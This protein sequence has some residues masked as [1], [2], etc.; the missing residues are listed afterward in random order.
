MK[1]RY[2]DNLVVDNFILWRNS[3]WICCNYYR[4]NLN[5][6]DIIATCYLNMS[7]ISAP[8]K[9]GMI[10]ENNPPTIC[11]NCVVIHNNYY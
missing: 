6:D 5:E 1:D 3:N 4:D 7:E 9:N 2:A 8:G 11:D 10:L